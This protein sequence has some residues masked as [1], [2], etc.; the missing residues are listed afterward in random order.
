ML[1]PTLC[2]CR[3]VFHFEKIPHETTPLSFQRQAEFDWLKTFLKFKFRM[4][5]KL[6]LPFM[7]GKIIL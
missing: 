2:L 3:Q 7:E 4:H 1:F 5:T 6:C